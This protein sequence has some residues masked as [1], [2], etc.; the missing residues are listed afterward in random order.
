MWIWWIV[1]TFL[2]FDMI[3]VKM[4]VKSSVYRSKT[5]AATQKKTQRNFLR[6]FFNKKKTSSHRITSPN[7]WSWILPDNNQS[8]VFF[9]KSYQ[10][11]LTSHDQTPTSW[12]LKKPSCYYMIS[13]TWESCSPRHSRWLSQNMCNHPLPTPNTNTQHTQTGLPDL[14]VWTFHPLVGGGPSFRPACR[15]QTCA[16]KKKM[17]IIYGVLLSL[18][19][20]MQKPGLELK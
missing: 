10:F 9:S 18:I 19:F 17:R 3:W 7:I 20:G 15:A 13:S 14:L 6:R 8:S 11:F 16:T 5:T 12:C 2:F 1:F 4:F